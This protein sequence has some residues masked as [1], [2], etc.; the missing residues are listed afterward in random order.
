[1]LFNSHPVDSSALLCNVSI[2][3]GSNPLITEEEEKKWESLFKKERFKDGRF[4]AA[5]KFST[6][7]L[8][9]TEHKTKTRHIKLLVDGYGLFKGAKEFW[10]AKVGTDNS[11]AILRIGAGALSGILNFFREQERLS[12][13]D[14]IFANDIFYLCYILDNEP[15]KIQERLARYKALSK[16]EY[17]STY[18]YAPVSE[19]Q[20]GAIIK[21]LKRAVADIGLSREKRRLEGWR[22][23]T[24]QYKEFL[25]K[26]PTRQFLE[27]A[28]S[29]GKPQ[30]H[31]HPNDIF[32]TIKEKQVDSKLIIEAMDAFHENT[33]DDLVVISNDT[34][35][36]PLEERFFSSHVQ[37]HQFP[38]GHFLEGKRPSKAIKINKNFD[39]DKYLSDKELF[40]QLLHDQ[41]KSVID[42]QNEIHIDFDPVYQS[43]EYET[44]LLKHTMLNSDEYAKVSRYE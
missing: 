27:G 40:A 3:L 11:E 22:I 6:R 39:R 31:Y 20:E 2:S 35:F 29:E 13:P 30:V 19:E 16:L 21:S 18:F 23:S 9:E 26:L 28:R 34:D 8:R 38:L 17:S 12:Q 4:E 42:A 37:Y 1:M 32:K 15:Q 24:A 33:C 36:L 43:E 41:L 5:E 25:T 7:I 10:K 44:E 14:T